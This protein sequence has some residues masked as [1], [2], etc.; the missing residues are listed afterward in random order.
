MS[1]YESLAFYCSSQEEDF[2]DADMDEGFDQN[3]H[4]HNL[5]RLSVCSSST[6]CGADDGDDN[7]LTMYLSNL[8]IES[9]E[10]EG[11]ADEELAD[12][13]KELP[14][15]LSSDSETELGGCY[16]L[17]ATPPRR[18][19]ARKNCA[20]DSERRKKS[21]EKARRKKREEGNEE[22][23]GLMVI[24]R[25]KGGRRSLCM[26]MGEVKACQELGFELEHERVL[27][28]PSRL[29]LDT[30]SSGG[31][32]PISNWR[33]SSPGDDPRDVKARLRVWAQAVAIA[34]ASKHAN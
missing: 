12:E 2:A 34:S 18:R 32:S 33:I 1:S 9:F 7:A 15:G 11:D 10:G 13:G 24:T 6:L 16:S 23:R 5:S 27:E 20:S 28:V 14:T 19:K 8:S 30:A 21:G 25:P 22:G 17:P 4:P 29:S 31:N 26:D 3:Q